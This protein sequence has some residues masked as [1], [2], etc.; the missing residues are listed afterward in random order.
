MGSLI[1]LGVGRG[2]AAD[3]AT[4]FPVDNKGNDPYVQ[5]GTSIDYVGYPYS[6][7]ALYKFVN[8]VGGTAHTFQINK[9]N[10][11]EVTISAVEVKNGRIIQDV[12]GAYVIGTNS[13]TS[14]SVT[15]T[16]PATIVA[17]CWGDYPQATVIA[18]VNNS[19][20]ILDQYPAVGGSSVQGASAS[21]DAATAGT[22]NVTWTIQGQVDGA[23]LFIVA[24]Q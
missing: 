11:D 13:L 23:I 24:V 7:A 15:T 14:P 19:F 22:F 2:V 21:L 6:G 20:K 12:K 3:L 17:F 4:V 18:S 1:L 8:A 16:G 9:L 5:V 10:G